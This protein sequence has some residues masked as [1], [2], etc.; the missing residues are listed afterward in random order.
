MPSRV[1]TVA[2]REGPRAAAVMLGAKAVGNVSS[3]V[4]AAAGRGQT[5]APATRIMLGAKAVQPCQAEVQ[6]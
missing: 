1:A 2:E 4:A 5:A 6:Q 3:R